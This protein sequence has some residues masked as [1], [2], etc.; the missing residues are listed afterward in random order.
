[1][2]YTYLLHGSSVTTGG[3]MT[4][5]GLV[6]VKVTV[7]GNAVTALVCASQDSL[8][9]ATC[10]IA[11]S[12]PAW[13]TYTGIRS[14]KKAIV[15]EGGHQTSFL[16]GTITFAGTQPDATA[17]SYVG[18]SHCQRANGAHGTMDNNGGGVPYCR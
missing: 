16:W 4:D 9:A 17:V 3:N 18:G 8:D 15:A 7:R 11:G 5:A 2:T 1:M 12:K 6:S 10:S 13:D 14:G